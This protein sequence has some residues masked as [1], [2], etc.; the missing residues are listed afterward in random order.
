MEFLPNSAAAAASSLMA[1][2][3]TPPPP[4]L[5]PPPWHSVGICGIQKLWFSSGNVI[6]PSHQLR[7]TGRMC[8]CV[9]VASPSTP[10]LGVVAVRDG[11]EDMYC[12]SAA[13]FEWEDKSPREFFSND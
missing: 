12:G 2:T 8:V 1:N 11:G 9:C 6:G 5:T 4:P 13:V 7:A 3:T 10:D